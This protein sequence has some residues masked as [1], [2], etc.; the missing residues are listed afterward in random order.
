MDS[1]K[2]VAA[3]S[4]GFVVVAMVGT[5]V[6][7]GISLEMVAGVVL[8]VIA[9]LGSESVRSVVS[10]TVFEGSWMVGVF[11]KSVCVVCCC[12]GRV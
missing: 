3:C 11:T 5:G 1:C 9:E 2:G 8:T 12:L 4:T 6:T 7:N 10:E